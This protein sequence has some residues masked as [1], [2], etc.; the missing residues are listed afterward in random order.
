VTLNVVAHAWSRLY[1]ASD[2]RITWVGGPRAP[3]DWPK[4]VSATGEGW[5]AL[6]AYNGLA[7]LE[8]K[9]AHRWVAE[10]VA[11]IQR[12]GV[13]FD[14]LLE[15][16]LKRLASAVR[17]ARLRPAALTIISAATNRGSLEIACLSNYEDIFAGSTRPV[18]DHFEMTKLTPKGPVVYL[19]GLRAAVDD[20][21]L[22]LL[23]R[24]LRR[25]RPDEA[26]Q[27]IA[28]LNR[29][30]SQAI[31]AGGGI[32]G[33][34]LVGRL[35]LSGASASRVFG[36]VTGPFMPESVM[37][38][39]DVGESIRELFAKGAFHDEWV[40]LADSE[41]LSEEDVWA[42][43]A[44]MSTAR[45]GHSSTTL[46]DGRVLVVG[47]IDG[48]HRALGSC[49]IYD[50]RDDAWL[51]TDSVADPRWNHTCVRLDDGRVLVCGGQG[52]GASTAEL[53]NPATERWESAGELRLPLHNHTATLLS[54]GRVIVAGGTASDVATD[55]VEWWR[56][57]SDRWVAGGRLRLARYQHAAVP[58]D[59]GRVALLG[60]NTGRNP[61]PV[62]RSIE[63]FDL[64]AGGSIRM[65]PLIRPRH[66]AVVALLPDQR[67]LIA[68][69]AIARS[70][71][72]RIE[73]HQRNDDGPE[74]VDTRFGGYAFDQAE[75][76]SV[77]V[78]GGQEAGTGRALAST[79]I[80]SVSAGM[81]KALGEMKQPRVDHAIARLSDGRFIACGGKTMV[82]RS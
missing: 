73:D 24:Q 56:P 75:D 33:A 3:E 68:G 52:P 64:E 6:L 19:G 65:R 66:L 32:S 31:A 46:P 13:G 67:V 61:D 43:A 80:F 82:S 11:D 16:V 39:I 34:C 78:V 57:G 23:K 5:N 14:E 47:G 30:A 36:D 60:G 35:E 29:A 15:E 49:E 79:E 41:I 42:P 37:M 74:M 76:G 81:W 21:A 18:D 59:G 27:H 20:R 54:D 48:E 10:I 50:P 69:A 12:S 70:E 17:S 28:E 53:F 44:P 40:T 7:E 58:L 72:I 45:S 22:K 25:D 38:G 2:V 55:A 1:L 8:G 51:G 71:L 9:T 26:M 77:I 4:T 62:V 63:V